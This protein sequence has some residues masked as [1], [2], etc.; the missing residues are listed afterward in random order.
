[1]ICI[2]LFELDYLYHQKEAS[3]LPLNPEQRFLNWLPLSTH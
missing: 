3:S 1:V 2:I